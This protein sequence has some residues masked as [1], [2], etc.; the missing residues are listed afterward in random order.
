ML[1]SAPRTALPIKITVVAVNKTLFSTA[2]IADPTKTVQAVVDSVLD[3]AK[4]GGVTFILE[5]VETFTTEEQLVG[6]VLPLAMLP[7]VTV[8]N[9]ADTFGR[10]IKLHALIEPVH[11]TGTPTATQL[12][13]VSSILG[14]RDREPALS[15]GFSDCS[16]GCVHVP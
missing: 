6:T 14:C 9:L 13:S 10:F 1:P 7:L 8:A 16:D 5:R 11:P 2:D 4:A 12:P 15:R 3:A